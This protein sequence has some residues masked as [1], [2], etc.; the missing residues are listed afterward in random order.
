MHLTGIVKRVRYRIAEPA[1]GLHTNGVQWKR[2]N[3]RWFNWNKSIKTVR[4]NLIF[5]SALEIHIH[6]HFQMGGSLIRFARDLIDLSEEETIR[7]RAAHMHWMMGSQEPNK[8][9]QMCAVRDFI[10]WKAIRTFLKT[11][12]FQPFC[13][14]CK[15]R[16][17]ALVT[18]R[19]QHYNRQWNLDSNTIIEEEEKLT[20]ITKWPKRKT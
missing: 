15:Y 4:K 5:W 6:T 17:R 18:T 9:N 3:S 10:C 19:R 11:I 12:F 1:W 14:R 8:W 2:Q 20:S 16:E 7:N 13:Y